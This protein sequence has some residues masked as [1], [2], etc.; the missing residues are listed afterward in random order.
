MIRRA[1]KKTASPKKR[2]SG[3]TGRAPIAYYESLYAAF[4]PQGWWPG[5]T[6][7]EIIA[8]A[9]LT[10][11]TAWTNVEKAIK[12][13]KRARL[14]VPARMR[15]ASN[16]E[17]ALLIKPAGYFNV[18]ARR[19]KN[20]TNH[21]FDNYGGSLDRFL[22]KDPAT[23]R[24]ELLGINGIGPETA[25]S[26]IL[27]AAGLP[28]FV[29]DAYTKRIALR[30]GLAN[31]KAG[32]EE[33]KAYFMENLPPDRALFNEYHALLVKTGK[34]YCKTGVPRCGLCPLNGFLR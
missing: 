29:V 7:F 14:L 11:N 34:D 27:Y 16:G 30:H 10:Q 23:L 2:R 21:L 28:E 6:R 32:Y 13:L 3:R 22:R 25:D 18:K 15:G 33:L 12:N 24:G 31:E 8:G 17:L 20:F 4:G 1:D 26:I 5:R 9:I 19:L